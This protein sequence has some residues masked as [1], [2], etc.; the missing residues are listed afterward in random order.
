MSRN[1]IATQ[2]ERHPKMI[3]FFFAVALLVGQIGNVAANA[4]E[5]CAGP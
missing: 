2:L 1:R 3:G 4:A 5:T